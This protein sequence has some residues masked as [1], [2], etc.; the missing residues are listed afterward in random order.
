MPEESKDDDVFANLTKAVEWSAEKIKIANES[1]VQSVS[2]IITKGTVIREVTPIIVSKREVLKNEVQSLQDAEF[3]TEPLQ[4]K[5]FIAP[6]SS[7]NIQSYKKNGDSEKNLENLENI[8]NKNAKS[9]VQVSV[10]TRPV[11]EISKQRP[12]A[13]GVPGSQGIGISPDRTDTE[14]DKNNT[15]STDAEIPN[16]SKSKHN[17]GKANMKNVV[18]ATMVAIGTAS[19]AIGVGMLGEKYIGKGGIKVMK[20]ESNTGFAAA[21]VGVAVVTAAAPGV[22]A[23][24]VAGV[25]L[26]KSRETITKKLNAPATM[27]KKTTLGATTSVRDLVNRKSQA[28][29]GMLVKSVEKS[30]S[31]STV[32]KSPKPR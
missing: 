25:A 23:G 10:V 3:I 4:K 7:G 20:P 22:V 9:S 29:K 1:R 6:T 28:M 15:S 16:K 12:L 2:S 13:P 19:P 31:D 21:A 32:D 5:L 30:N 11:A 24:V 17:T 27:I 18:N 14:E 26:E 8:E